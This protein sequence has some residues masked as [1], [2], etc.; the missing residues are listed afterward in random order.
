MNGEATGR[1]LDMIGHSYY[2]SGLE[3]NFAQD[4]EQLIGVGLAVH[5][6]IDYES[7]QLGVLITGQGINVDNFTVTF[8][9]SPIPKNIG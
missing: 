5:H 8:T 6:G 4:M 2:T 3:E 7:Y 9:F 1:M